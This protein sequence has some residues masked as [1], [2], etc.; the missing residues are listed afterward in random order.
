MG[1]SSLRN[2]RANLMAQD[3]HCGNCGIE[4]IWYR[5]GPGEVLPDNFATI[6]HVNS[7]W[8]PVRDPI[9]GQMGRPRGGKRVLWCRGCNRDGNK[10]EQ[11]AASMEE[12]WRRSQRSPRSTR[13]A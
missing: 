13:A 11:E 12:K 1:K 2:R 10:R 3:P 7:R 9:T 4:V 6:E 5:P 8:H